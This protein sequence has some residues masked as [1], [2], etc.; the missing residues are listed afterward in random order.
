MAAERSGLVANFSRVFTTGSL[1]LRRRIIAIYVVLIGF[2]LLTW[3]AAI[4]AFGTSYPALLGT[5]LLAYS[6]GLRHAVDA[7]HISAIDNVTRKLMQERKRPVGVGLFFSLGHS[8][9]V[10]G[11]CIVIALAE[12]FVQKNIPT[13]RN[14]G[15]LIGTSV[16]ALFLLIIAAINLLVLWDI[17]QTFQKVKRGEEYNEQTLNEFLDQRGLMGRFFRPLMRIVNHSWNMY[18]IGVL[19]G[20]GFDTAT[21]VGILVVSAAA[22]SKGLPTAY[23]LIFPALFMAG[24]T[25]LD[26]TDGILMLGAYGWAFLKP[27]RKLYYNLNITLISVL[28]ALVIG[29]IEALSVISTQLNLSGGFW[30]LV[31]NLDLNTLGFFIIGIF[32][33]SWLISALIYKVR[34]YDQL[35]VKMAQ[36]SPGPAE[37]EMEAAGRRA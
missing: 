23:I 7:D 34:R 12:S 1:D 8:T 19:F 27:V 18:P 6:F 35:D 28:V 36:T 20:L 3:A 31:N 17:F 29:G 26:T 9:I 37:E 32:I 30:N 25:L 5:A 13:L 10:V 16:S 4:V 21:E 14:A 11:L 33:L 2:N 24:M 22:A 15:G